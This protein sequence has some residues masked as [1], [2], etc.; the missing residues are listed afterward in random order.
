MSRKR[1][2]TSSVEPDSPSPVERHLST[3][4]PQSDDEVEARTST[5]PKLD[6]LYGQHGAFPDLGDEDG[7]ELFYGPASD[8]LEYLRMV[9]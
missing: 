5:Q 9:R 2:N 8:G 6:P 3:S 1:R 7:E 4:P